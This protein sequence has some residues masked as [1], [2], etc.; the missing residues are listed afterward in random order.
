MEGR[1]EK[2]ARQGCWQRKRSRKRTWTWARSWSGRGHGVPG[3]GRG[4][5]KA[6]GSDNAQGC[7]RGRDRGR[8]QHYDDE[9][10]NTEQQ[11][12][13]WD[14]DVQG[15]EEQEFHP[16][17]E[18]GAQFPE[19]FHPNGQVSFFMLFF[20]QAVAANITGFTNDYAWSQIEYNQAYSGPQ[21]A[22]TETNVA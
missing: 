13:S 14:D 18:P 5:G 7:G 4:R 8:G 19:N 10:G 11:P 17:Q 1:S 9:D 22:W 15:P 3:Q 16:L 2:R 6:R 12:L 21:G 20:T